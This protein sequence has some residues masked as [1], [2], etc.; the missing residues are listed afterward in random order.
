[1]KFRQPESVTSLRAS[2]PIQYGGAYDNRSISN[3]HI[4]NLVQ[5]KDKQSRNKQEMH[6]SVPTTIQGYKQVT[7]GF[8]DRSDFTKVPQQGHDPGFVYNPEKSLTIANSVAETKKRAGNKDTS[9]GNA[10]RA[11]EKAMVPE[12]KEHW[13]GRGPA[14]R[15]GNQSVDL[16]LLK[17]KVQTFAEPKR[18]RGLLI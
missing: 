1:M 9:F 6:M 10:Y 16:K 13:Y 3:G 4:G 14:C 8:G 12:G 2:L 17:K 15:L 18:D 7:M 11:Y 5:V